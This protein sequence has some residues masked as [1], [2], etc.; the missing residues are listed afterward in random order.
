MVRVIGTFDGNPLTL[1]SGVNVSFITR[2]GPGR[3]RI[4]FTEPMP[5]YGYSIAGNCNSAADSGATANTAFMERKGLRT[6]TSVGVLCRTSS[7]TDQDRDFI[8]FMIAR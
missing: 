3:Y 7:G 2:D 1:L 4:F 6:L 8:S 5:D